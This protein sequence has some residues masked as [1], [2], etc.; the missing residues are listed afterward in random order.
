M[1]SPLKIRILSTAKRAEAK[2]CEL[3]DMPRGSQVAG[4]HNLALILF[5]MSEPTETG[6]KIDLFH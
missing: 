6:Y 4:S 3:A 1:D 2:M 5:D